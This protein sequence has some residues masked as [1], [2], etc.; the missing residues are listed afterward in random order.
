MNP[1]NTPEMKE[2]IRQ[3]RKNSETAPINVANLEN[4]LMGNE[5]KTGIE[6]QMPYM[7]A[8]ERLI[9]ELQNHD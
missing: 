9:I 1:L 3:L 6:K 4:W 8:N 2:E 5:D 7:P